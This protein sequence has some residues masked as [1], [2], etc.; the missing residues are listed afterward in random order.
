M[1]VWRKRA[2]RPQTRP[3]VSAICGGGEYV[4]GDLDGPA[5]ELVGPVERDR[6]ERADVAHRDQL[7]RK[8]RP[9][10]EAD[11]E[12][13][14]VQDRAVVGGEIVHEGD[15]AQD[16]RRKPERVDVLFDPRLALVVRDSRTGARAIERAVHEMLDAGFPGEVGHRLP[17]PFLRRRRLRG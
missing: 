10:G 14:V 17:P 13:A 8:L 3:K 16:G 4:P 5:E 2:G 12:L 15:G 9:D 1:G 6:R 7:H 11:H